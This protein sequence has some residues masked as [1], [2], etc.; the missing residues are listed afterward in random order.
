MNS[1]TTIT[2]ASSHSTLDDLNQLLDPAHLYCNEHKKLKKYYLRNEDYFLC[3]YDGYESYKNY[4]HFKEILTEY[5]EEVQRLKDAE[6]SQKEVVKQETSEKLSTSVNKVKSHAEFFFKLMEN[7]QIGYVRKLEKLTYINSEILKIKDIL[8]HISFRDDGS[9]NFINIGANEQKELKILTLANILV[10]RRLGNNDS[11]INY[12]KV[13]VE[14]LREFHY[15]LVALARSGRNWIE[16]SATEIYHELNSI[17]DSHFKSDLS[18]QEFA[19]QIYFS[20][21]VD[22]IIR[23]YQAQVTERDV[24]IE[25]LR[26]QN[27]ALN[28]SL[29]ERNSTISQLNITI[30]QNTVRI[31]ED[32]NIIIN[33]KNSIEELNR[34]YAELLNEKNAIADRLNK[35]IITHESLILE[36]NSSKE[37]FDRTVRLHLTQIEEYNSIKKRLEAEL[38]DERNKYKL[39]LVEYE[40]LKKLYADLAGENEMVVSESNDKDVQMKRMLEKFEITLGGLEAENKRLLAIIS[41]HENTIKQLNLTLEQTTSKYELALKDERNRYNLLVI[42]FEKLQN[43]LNKLNIHISELNITIKNYELKISDLEKRLREAQEHGQEGWSKYNLLVIEFGNLQNEL[44]R[45]NNHNTT[46]IS[47]LNIT[48]KN[49]ELKIS[50]LE[51]RLREAQEHG[52]DGWSKYNLL[53][54]QFENLQGELTRLNGQNTTIINELN[55]TIRN[56]ELKISE[57]ERRLHEAQENGAEGWA[58]YNLLCEENAKLKKIIFELENKLNELNI[59]ISQLSHKLEIS[60]CEIR[61]LQAEIVELNKEKQILFESE[62]KLIDE[63][64]AL[65]DELEALK[66]SHAELLLE[67]KSQVKQNEI[68]SLQVEE[69]EFTLKSESSKSQEITIIQSSKT[70]EFRSKMDLYI[71]S[72]EK[73]ENE[74]SEKK[75]VITHLNSELEILRAKYE[76]SLND[77]A[78]QKQQL[79]SIPV[80]EENLDLLGRQVDEVSNL[81]KKLELT[82]TH[83][84]ALILQL[85]QELEKCRNQNEEFSIVI[86]KNKESI[87]NLHNYESKLNALEHTRL[88]I[89]ELK[90]KI[91]EAEDLNR[92]SY[93]NTRQR[94]SKSIFNRSVVENLDKFGSAASEEITTTVKVIH[95]NNNNNSNY[96][97][98]NISS[99]SSLNGHLA[100]NNIQVIKKEVIL[101][102]EAQIVSCAAPVNPNNRA[103]STEYI[104]SDFKNEFFTGVPHSL[105]ESIVVITTEETSSNLVNQSQSNQISEWV[106]ESLKISNLNLRLLFKASRDGYSAEAFKSKCERKANTVTVA[107]TNHGK[108]IGGFTTIA[109]ETPTE[110][111]HVY[112]EDESETSFLFSLTYNEKYP[113]KHELRQFAVCNTQSLGPLFGG[114]SDLEIV[115]DCN[116]NYNSFSG[117]D[118]TYASKRNPHEFYGDEKYLI[119]DYEVYEVYKRE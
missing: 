23:G 118:H 67:L 61:T 28:A 29:N 113:I 57:L 72:K 36:F 106:T 66:K 54:I 65:S 13:F 96:H 85:E 10:R 104:T 75:N 68:L 62:G 111:S 47:E 97:I 44:T 30:S 16:S 26:N 3:E 90:R 39:L 64:N 50:D 25:S 78:S 34:K 45:L 8:T 20:E 95:D 55:I 73:L 12:T 114:G 84:D 38:S 11:E 24:I 112:E 43:E 107:R 7:F 109:W 93:R 21:E 14:F 117:T 98:S 51:K 46:I 94:R 31:Q 1:N 71:S 81:N 35:L 99:A 74:L 100:N 33:L 4:C 86:T 83:K 60:L 105:T 41:N 48:I 79:K 91:K 2:T 115:D 52:Q 15:C 59:I 70:T 92:S 37:N 88:E 42:E 116:V 82:I 49:Y 53:V 18:N 87:V 119:Q 89:E 80:L 22:D 9:V 63:N 17:E 102:E 6:V 58:K 101:S 69:L 110:G 108:L 19:R 40:K 56:F 32:H 27:S 76:A 77:I 103:I 5:K